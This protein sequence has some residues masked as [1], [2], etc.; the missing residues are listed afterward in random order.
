M[1]GVLLRRCLSCQNAAAD[2]K[3]F[4]DYRNAASPTEAQAKAAQNAVWQKAGL[5][6][7]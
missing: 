1:L 7:A 3:A 5:A 2:L 6:S 4:T